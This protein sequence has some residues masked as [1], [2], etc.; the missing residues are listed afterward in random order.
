MRLVRAIDIHSF[1]ALLQDIQS[2]MALLSAE[3]CFAPG[4]DRPAVLLP[5]NED[6]IQLKQEACTKDQDDRSTASTGNQRDFLVEGDETEEEDDEDER[7]PETD[8][9]TAGYDILYRNRHVDRN[10]EGIQLKPEAC[11]EEQDDRNGSSGSLSR[12][13]IQIERRRRQPR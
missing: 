1:P 10:E 2:K 9:M 11:L 6:A 7:T 5:R 12:D 13:A 4:Q 8:Q 3:G